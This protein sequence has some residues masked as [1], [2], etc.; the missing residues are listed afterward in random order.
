[1]DRIRRSIISLVVMI[2][3]AAT[4]LFCLAP[5]VSSL[6]NEERLRLLEDRYLKGEVPADVFLK[7]SKKYEQQLSVNQKESEEVIEPG[8]F[9]YGCWIEAES[10]S[11][12]NMLPG[13]DSENNFS[14]G[15]M[16]YLFTTE[17]PAE[18]YYFA[19]YDLEIPEDGSYNIW[20]HGTSQNTE[21]RSIF[22][23]SID[24]GPL[25]SPRIGSVS[26]AS[27][28]GKDSNNAIWTKIG[29]VKISRGKHKLLIKPLRNTKQQKFF[30]VFDCIAF[31]NSKYSTWMPECTPES[32]GI[33]RPPVEPS[34]KEFD[35]FP[36]KVEWG[37]GILEVDF[38]QVGS[39]SPV[40]MRLQRE[41]SFTSIPEDFQ[42]LMN[43]AQADIPAGR[44]V[45]MW[46]LFEDAMGEEFQLLLAMRVYDAWRQYQIN[47]VELIGSSDTHKSSAY[48]SNEKDAAGLPLSLENN[49]TRLSGK[50][51][52]AVDLPL[53][54]K[55]LRM[56]MGKP[57]PE[58][59]YFDNL[60]VSGKLVEDFEDMKD[61]KVITPDSTFK[62]LVYSSTKRK[63]GWGRFFCQVDPIYL[64][65][66]LTTWVAFEYDADI[67]YVPSHVRLQIDL[68]EGIHI[69]SR[70]VT[71]VWQGEAVPIVKE[72]GKVK[73]DG[74]EYT[75]YRAVCKPFFYGI[76]AWTGLCGYPPL[77]LFL[78]TDLKAGSKT[79]I[80]H[81]TLW[82]QGED[83]REDKEIIHPVEVLEVKE[84][85]P[86][87]KFV[88]GVWAP[89]FG[90]ESPFPE[91]FY[92]KIGLADIFSNIEQDMIPLLKKVGYRSLFP[93]C[94]GEMRSVREAYCTLIDGKKLLIPREGVP[95]YCPTYR[96]EAVQ[97]Y[98]GQTA[99]YARQGYD[100]IV[101]GFGEPGSSYNRESMGEICFGSRCLGRYKDFMKNKYPHMK[102]ISPKVFEKEW[103]KYPE[104]HKTWYDFKTDMY[105]EWVRLYVNKFKQEAVASGR[106]ESDLQFILR[107]GVM[108]GVF[109]EKTQSSIDPE[110]GFPY[111]WTYCVDYT[112]LAE[113]IGIFL[114][115]IDCPYTI[116]RVGNNVRARREL[117]GEDSKA[118]IVPLLAC[119][120]SIFWSSGGN[121][122]HRW[123]K[124]I[125]ETFKY[126]LFEC[127]AN[128]AK[129]FGYLTEG[130]VDGLDQ[131]GIVDTINIVKSV[132]DVIMDGKL[133]PV[134]KFK[135]KV[136][137]R[138][139][140]VGT[141][142]EAVVMVA[143]YTYDPRSY[144]NTS[145]GD[146]ETEITFADARSGQKVIDLETGE[147][148]GTFSRRNRSF[149][150]SIKQYKCR[151]LYI[152][153]R[154]KVGLR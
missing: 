59:I 123:H 81:Q 113:C 154:R 6:T 133:I 66:D 64:A 105:A 76:T 16:L 34:K 11:K 132:E 136:P 118:K 36:E 153:H 80:Y 152:G 143:N 111:C 40:D 90:K 24:G 85:T 41:V 127:I 54:F 140:G 83:D 35:F 97:K 67:T 139:R 38:S 95:M 5:D 79:K 135:S 52:G 49:P 32:D 102:Y 108:G 15:R 106:A 88:T 86:P 60:I 50:G 72:L 89:R 71:M 150:L 98:S 61:W 8:M 131:K 69:A 4:I 63:G 141:E 9:S 121:I 84:T 103:K 14:E 37:Y 124:E 116:P 31:I 145:E 74:Q 58:K 28:S 44:T 13:G 149:P 142:K 146:V 101:I 110:T 120:Y 137:L 144:A 30:G 117:L 57:K 33:K 112:K 87:E 1:M 68:P 151:L 19:E 148:L 39:W 92:L 42:I 119:R 75:R 91:D 93:G 109:D 147:V 77:R 26:F 53:K 107:P 100:G 51:K 99:G 126:M 104:Y 130:S 129:G 45:K 29:R 122:G 55:G 125:P 96:G 70:P 23:W 27:S 22:Q 78:K 73:H 46:A 134:E 56:I 43:A 18:G 2:V 17:V 25:Q 62:P 7:L 65:S 138:I 114:D 48:D 82:K 21:W 115:Q 3:V 10:T 128:G 20:F 47:P 12:H 94:I